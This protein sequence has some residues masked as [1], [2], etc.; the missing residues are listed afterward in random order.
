MGQTIRRT[1][2]MKM[3]VCADAIVKMAQD[4][5]DHGTRH[6]IPSNRHMVYR[7]EV[8]L[9]QETKVRGQ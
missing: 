9:H 4:N 3:G 2:H 6:V 1:V 8:E 7:R 5:L